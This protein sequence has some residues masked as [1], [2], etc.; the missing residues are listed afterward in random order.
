MIVRSLL[1]V[2]GYKS[3]TQK[4]NNYNQALQKLIGFA[5]VAAVAVAGLGVAFVKSAGEMEQTEIAFETMLGSAEEAQKLLKDVRDFAVKTP[6]QLNELIESSKQLQI[7]KFRTEEIIP[8]MKTLGDIAAGVGREKLPQIIQAFGRIKLFGVASMREI[9]SLTFANIPILDALAKRFNIA[10]DNMDELKKMIS[11]GKVSFEDVQAAMKD[12]S[13]TKFANLMEKQMN[14]FFGI[15]SNIQDWFTKISVAIGQNIL[16]KIKAIAAA[17]RDFLGFNFDD[18]VSGFTNFFDTIIKGI[19]FAF[20]FIK[21]LYK[22]LAKTGIFKSLQK[23]AMT[24]YKSAKDFFK[25]LLP[26]LGGLWKG[27]IKPLIEFV[28]RH[29]KTFAELGEAIRGVAGSFKGWG[30]VQN[31][32]NAMQKANPIKFLL[33][34]LNLIMQGILFLVRNWD[35]MIKWLND[36]GQKIIDFLT[37]IWE[38][39]MDFWIGVWDTIS[40]TAIDIWN[41]IV[42]FLEESGIIDTLKSAWDGFLNYWQEAWDKISQIAKMVWDAIVKSISDSWNKLIE[43]ITKLWEDFVNFFEPIRKLIDDILGKSEKMPNLFDMEE[44]KNKK[45]GKKESGTFKPENNNPEKKSRFNSPFGNPG[46]NPFE[47][48]IGFK[49]INNSN[50]KGNTMVATTVN[51]TLPPGTP[52]EHIRM[53]KENT[54]RIINEAIDKRLKQ[55]L[56]NI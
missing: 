44:D 37:E 52:E 16:P 50:V 33:A 8:T 56:V 2:L 13:E 6:F 12:I 17:F 34:P 19:L 38:E 3:D 35:N 45:K 27:L 49:T 11:A 24:I 48:E 32:I 4:L 30:I 26:I 54:D 31:I 42:T 41:G 43:D 39:F 29:I 47:K 1:T 23:A 10:A 7:F 40:N 20:F 14:T 18:I 53:V 51:M 46:T 55:G 5:K 28:A 25:F 36:T 21:R 15:V 9:K 22:E